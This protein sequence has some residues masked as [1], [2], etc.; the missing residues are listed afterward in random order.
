MAEAIVI[1]GNEP[2]LSGAHDD[3]Y[4]AWLCLPIEQ[5]RQHDGVGVIRVCLGVFPEAE[6][7]AAIQR[8]CDFHWPGKCKWDG[9][10]HHEDDYRI[11]RGFLHRRG[12][13]KR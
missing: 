7:I 3:L 1:T 8:V 13:P 4:E 6:A 5:L 9:Q 11:N 10:M 2:S 12:D